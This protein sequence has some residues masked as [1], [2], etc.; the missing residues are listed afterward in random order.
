[1]VEQLAYRRRDDRDRPA[2]RPG[3]AS[4]TG[5]GTSPLPEGLSEFFPDEVAMIMNCFRRE[6]TTLA[7][8]AWTLMHRLPGRRAPVSGRSGRSGRS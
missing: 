8:A 7:A 3:A 5:A 6:A 1:M 4:P 2:G